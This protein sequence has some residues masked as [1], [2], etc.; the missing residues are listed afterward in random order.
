[1]L[2]H[3]TQPDIVGVV[4][5]KETHVSA[6][7]YVSNLP[8]SVTQEVLAGIFAEFGTVWRAARS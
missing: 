8:P 7:L 5:T 2:V 4:P 1:V 6:S 3:W